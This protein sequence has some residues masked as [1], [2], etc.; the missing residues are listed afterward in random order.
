MGLFAPTYEEL[1]TNSRSRL[2]NLLFNHN[3]S[4]IHTD[5]VARYWIRNGELPEEYH[6]KEELQSNN[7]IQN[8]NIKEGGNSHMYGLRRGYLFNEADNNDEPAWY[9]PIHAIGRGAGYVAKRLDQGFSKSYGGA[10]NLNQLGYG[11][12]KLAEAL[13]GECGECG[14]EQSGISLGVG[15]G[16]AFDDGNRLYNIGINQYHDSD[17]SFIGDGDDPNTSRINI[18]A[19]IAARMAGGTP[20]PYTLHNGINRRSLSSPFRLRPLRDDLGPN[21]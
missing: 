9:N 10:R 7:G 20:D 15:L 8:E 19:I 21:G 3:K 17:A 12:S 11:K 16:K 2:S 4:N 6:H 14:C 13:M 18:P 5:K 1:A